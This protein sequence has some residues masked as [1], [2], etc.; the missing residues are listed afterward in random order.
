MRKLLLVT[1]I[2]SLVIFTQADLERKKKVKTLSAFKDCIKN[3]YHQ[4]SKCTVDRK[5]RDLWHDFKGNRKEIITV[6]KSCCLKNESDANE[7][8]KGDSF[9]TCAQFY[10]EAELWGCK[11][12]KTHGESHGD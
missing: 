10:C 6:L 4:F 12:V 7:A 1:L 3:C 9:A 2:L 11:V 5:L 8:T